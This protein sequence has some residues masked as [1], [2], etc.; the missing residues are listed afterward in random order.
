M[1]R[2]GHRSLPGT[3]A[4]ALSSAQGHPCLL[5]PRTPRLRPPTKSKAGRPLQSSCHLVSSP[6]GLKSDISVTIMLTVEA[7]CADAQ[8]WAREGC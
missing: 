1:G 7:K 2:A 6:Q 4:Q 5:Y 3:A 8:V